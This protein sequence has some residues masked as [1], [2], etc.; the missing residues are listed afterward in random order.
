MDS[1]VSPEVKFDIPPYNN[2]LV[3][4]EL[5]G[6]DPKKAVG[7][8]GVSSKILKVAAPSVALVVTKIINLTIA[9]NCF[10]ILWKLA[11]VCP[12]FNSGKYDERTNYRPISILFVLSKILEKHVHKYLYA[13]LIQYNLIH[14]PIWF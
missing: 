13:F 8:D 9:T 6:L 7:T 10:P 3:Q 14:S 12:V 1:K 5:L 2:I 11:R 4:K